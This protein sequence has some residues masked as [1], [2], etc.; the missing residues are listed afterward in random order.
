MY[1]CK[2]GKQEAGSVFQ[3]PSDSASD[4]TQCKMG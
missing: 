1:P 3:I 2:N 4:A